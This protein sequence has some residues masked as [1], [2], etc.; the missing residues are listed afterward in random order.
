MAKHRIADL[1]NNDL[2]EY[3]ARGPRDLRK[4]SVNK[5]LEIRMSF[6]VLQ[7]VSVIIH[8]VFAR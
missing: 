8:S 3:G 6:V 5:R 7:Y 4:R 2:S 1:E